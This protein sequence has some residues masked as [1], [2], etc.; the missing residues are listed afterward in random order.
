MTLMFGWDASK[1]STTP[2]IAA[3]SRSVK[4]CQNVIV[5]EAVTP[6]E[7]IGLLAWVLGVH[8]AA[9][10]T[11]AAPIA[12]TPTRRVRWRRAAIAPSRCDWRR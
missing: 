12:T 4:K 6:G 2:W 3:D 1:S 7:A 9:A 10:V 8:A 11:I 5:P